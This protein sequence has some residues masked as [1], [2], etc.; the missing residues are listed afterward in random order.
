M[1]RVS[2]ILGQKL[3]YDSGEMQPTPRKASKTVPEKT[4]L[5][6]QQTETQT[7]T[8]TIP[9]QTVPEHTCRVIYWR[10]RL[11]D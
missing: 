7:E 2:G 5:E 9:E 3:G 1:A 11:F 10:S 6:N 8:Q 4:V